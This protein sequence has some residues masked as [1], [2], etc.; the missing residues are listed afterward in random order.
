MRLLRRHLLSS[1]AAPF[2]F[3]WIAQTAMLMLNQLSRQLGD[4]VGK[5]LPGRVIA[6]AL[7][8]MI[9]FIVALT[10]PM[11]VLVAVLY[12]FSQMGADNELT[13]MRANGVS[14]LQM[15]RPVLA[16]GLVMTVA[17]FLFIDQ[18]LPRGN[19]RLSSLRS[20]IGNKKPTFALK[21]Q[22]INPVPQSMYF[23]RASRI[24][25]GTGRMR[26]VVIYDLSPP[27]ARRVIHADSGFMAW[28]RNNQ[29]LGIVLHDGEVHEYQTNEPTS[30]S[31][32]RFAVNHLTVRNLQNAFR[33]SVGV[34][35]AGDREMTT[36]QMMDRVARSREEIARVRDRRELIAG[37]G[38]RAQLR[39]AQIPDS[40]RAPA[41]AI[42]PR[43]AVL[44]R[45][46]EQWTG[47]LLLPRDATAQ[48]PPAARPDSAAGRSPVAPVPVIAPL[49]VPASISEVAGVRDQEMIARRDM[50]QF[51][52]EIHK[53]FSLA[54]ACTTFV[55]IGI[56][57]ALRFPRGGMGLVIG[58]SLVIFS[59]FYVGL[60][61]GENLGDRGVMDP[62]LA[63]WL[64]NLVVFVA[65]VLGLIR[66][67]R[68]FGSTRGGDLADLS[69]WLLGWLP[70]RRTARAE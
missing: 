23:V 66:V 45:R 20:D 7:I 57:L 67:N 56:A 54:V 46:F 25:P 21:E 24:D 35:E 34:V 31:L 44:W 62:A 19:L 18:V 30:L 48:N 13:A 42:P 1:L 32:T 47:R 8:L 5:G 69:E 29:D 55:L 11:A 40:V 53:K 12:A 50:R 64:P 52:V 49:P 4:L 43:C 39:L 37:N 27:T 33:Q 65:G 60:T 22:A 28:E 17:N 2:V 26:E 58:A 9:P 41:P 6:E 59:V 38:V 51:T 3:A 61:V 15:L 16:A 36:C 63:M 70:R 10:L 14:V 68:E